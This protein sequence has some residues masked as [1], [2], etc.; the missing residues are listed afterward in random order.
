MKINDNYLKLKDSYLFSMIAKKVREHAAVS[1]EKI[2]RLGIG[3]V[4][5][6][7][8]PA[9]VDAMREAVLEMGSKETFKG[10]GEEQGY[11]F[12]RQ[13]ICG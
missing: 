3:D 4:T 7:L 1:N 10:Y 9:V 11:S 13:A 8:V 12:L 2:I 5:L 6:P